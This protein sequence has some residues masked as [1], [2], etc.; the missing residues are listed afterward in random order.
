VLDE[1]FATPP[2]MDLQITRAEWVGNTVEVEGNWGGEISSAHCDL[3]EGGGEN[4]R[5][6][7]WWDRSVVPSMVWS[8][9]TFTQIFVEAEEAE[10]SID[11]AA[12]YTVICLGAFADGW[13]T[14][15]GAAVGGEPSG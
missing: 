3:F 9:R 14:N 10:D 13:S 1:Q 11:P 15:D 5:V 12:E 4:Q 8:E 7:D 6:T 2:G